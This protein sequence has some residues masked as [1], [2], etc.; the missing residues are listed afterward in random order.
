[1]MGKGVGE[2]ASLCKKN[3]VPCIGF[4][5]AVPDVDKA[6]QLFS[7]TF[8]LTP[9]FTSREKAMAEP[10]VWLA[11]LAAEAARNWTD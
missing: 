1:M 9:V 7:K 5:G 8:A 6:Q 3:A 10:G 11:R 4:A 2:L